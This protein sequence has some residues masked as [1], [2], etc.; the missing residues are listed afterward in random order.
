MWATKSNGTPYCEIVKSMLTLSV[1]IIWRER[2]FKLLLE[3][4]VKT[5]LMFIYIGLIFSPLS[6]TMLI[7]YLLHLAS[8]GML[9][10]CIIGFELT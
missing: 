7:E 10:F 6:L 1:Y 4:N 9:R 3:I 8:W 5:W 2:N